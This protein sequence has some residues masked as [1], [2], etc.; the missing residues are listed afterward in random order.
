MALRDVS[1][2]VNRFWKERKRRRIAIYGES[3]SKIIECIN[4]KKVLMIAIDVE[5]MAKKKF[6][7]LLKKKQK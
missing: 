7:K 1:E 4:E 5:R 6:K 3:F 2:M